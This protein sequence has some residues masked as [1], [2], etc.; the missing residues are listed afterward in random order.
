MRSWGNGISCDRA[1]T[2]GLH[3]TGL[4]VQSG[5]RLNLAGTT[6]VVMAT[7]RKD[8]VR[9]SGGVQQQNAIGFVQSEFT[10]TTLKGELE[11]RG[12]LFKDLVHLTVGITPKNYP[13]YR[14]GQSDIGG[15]GAVAVRLG[16]ST[17]ALG[18]RRSFDDSMLRF[19]LS[20]S[21]SVDLAITKQRFEH[22]ADFHYRRIATMDTA[23]LSWLFQST[24]HSQL[25]VHTHYIAHRS[26]DVQSTSDYLWGT[27]TGGG[28][29]VSLRQQMG[30]R[31]QF[32]FTT[33]LQ[34]QRGSTSMGYRSDDKQNSSSVVRNMPWHQLLVSWQSQLRFRDTGGNEKE[35]GL[36]VRMQNTTAPRMS[37]FN[38]AKFSG[39][40]NGVSTV[41]GAIALQ[42]YEL[43]YENKRIA[44][45]LPWFYSVALSH[46]AMQAEVDKK[47]MLKATQ[48]TLRFAVRSLSFA[49]LQFGGRIGSFSWGRL[50]L[51]V[52][53]AFILQLRT[54]PG[55]SALSDVSTAQRQSGIDYPWIFSGG[56]TLV[57]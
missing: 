51:W 3:Y 28:V 25:Q 6:L 10:N 38:G 32:D 50:S 45:R 33:E 20:V 40:S 12:A 19:S 53:L 56:M 31:V 17:L 41:A 54:D 16:T 2:T 47:D 37:L 5:A 7:L 48:Q 34:G 24:E 23:Y 46:T 52:A 26:N 43:K 30:Q 11:W 36:S 44:A 39:V 21:D 15:H 9:L 35:F 4:A 13:Q 57:L 49:T 1:K 29:A 8:H 22:Q 27:A 42:M 55:V 14:A 18:A